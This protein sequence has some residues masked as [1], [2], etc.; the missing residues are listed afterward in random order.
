VKAARHSDSDEV[1]HTYNPYSF[2]RLERAIFKNNLKDVAALR[3]TAS[4]INKF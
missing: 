2:A 1:D 3:E 4:A